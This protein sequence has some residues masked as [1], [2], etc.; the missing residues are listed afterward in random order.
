M[1]IRGSLRAGPL[2]DAPSSARPTS[3]PRPSTGGPPAPQPM[4]NWTSSRKA[5]SRVIRAPI[6]S[7]RLPTKRLRA[8]AGTA[9][10]SSSESVTQRPEYLVVASSGVPRG[11]A[12]LGF[13]IRIITVGRG[14]P[15]LGLED[16]AGQ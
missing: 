4:P 9:Y 13:A 15:K 7:R 2:L 10:P 8:S 5:A 6:C 12:I 3:C 16:G 1:G 11:L 14:R